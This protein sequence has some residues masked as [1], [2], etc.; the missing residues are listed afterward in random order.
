MYR[1]LD[2]LED[3]IVAGPYKFLAVAN[4]QKRK[5]GRRDRFVVIHDLPEE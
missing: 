3:K 1:V 5:L 4:A 2:T